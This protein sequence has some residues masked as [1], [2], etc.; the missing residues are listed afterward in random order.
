[1]LFALIAIIAVAVVA[2]F[3]GWVAGLI[4]G[5]VVL[6]VFFLVVLVASRQAQ[7]QS[8]HG[9]RDLSAEAERIAVLHGISVGGGGSSKEYAE[10]GRKLYEDF[11]GKGLTPSEAIDAVKDYFDREI[12]TL[13]QQQLA[14]MTRR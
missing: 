6:V 5:V 13:E 12:D 11:K 9:N 7:T 10:R 2:G 8:T 14:E 1:M 3:W 4:T